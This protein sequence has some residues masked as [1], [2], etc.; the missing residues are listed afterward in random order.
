[1]TIEG[2]EIRAGAASI[3][4]NVA[5][6]AQNAAIKGLEF[7]C[8]I[9]GTIG[10]GLR[11]NAGSYGREFK[12]IVMSADVIERDGTKRTLLNGQVGFSYR[13][14]DV[15]A[16]TIF[17]SALLQGDAGDP[18]EIQARMADIQKSRSDS[19]PI[20]EKTGGSTFANPEGDPQKRHAWQL[21]EAAGC[22]GL[23]IGQ[24]KVSEKH[25]NFLINTGRAT[26][27]EIEHLGEEVRRRVQEHSGIDLRWEIK[28]IGVAVQKKMS[29]GL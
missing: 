21:I 1:L 4:L 17:V 10:G 15:A 11:M 12:D 14:T 25:C 7:L 8:G 3:D 19:Q 26:A 20:R 29:D 13:H 27:S 6:A 28:R 5:R 22:R 24:A 2:E 9:P 18:A 23:K 16:D